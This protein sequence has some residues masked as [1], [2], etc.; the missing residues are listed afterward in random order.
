MTINRTKLRDLSFKIIF[1]YDFYPNPELDVQLDNFLS[2]EEEISDE[3]KAEIRARS[4][5][6]FQKIALIDEKIN[7]KAENW[8]TSRMSRVDLSIIRLA[9]Y[10]MENDE[11][12]PE[13]V[14]IN[15]AVELAKLYGGDESPKFVNGVLA[16]IVKKDE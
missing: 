13:K 1:E 8:T 15:E 4:V 2:L 12:V 16:R 6:I 11:E 5:D 9:I 10:E 14:A 3:D 7:E